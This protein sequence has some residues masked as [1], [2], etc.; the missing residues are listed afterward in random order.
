MFLFEDES[1][2]DQDLL[3]DVLNMFFKNTP[4]SVKPSIEGYRIE[5][6]EYVL[7]C[8][9]GPSCDMS[10]LFHEMGH[11]AEREIPKLLE[12]PWSG[13]GYGQG[14][15]WEFGGRFGFE[16]QTDQSVRREARIWAFQLS[17]QRYFGIQ[18]SPYDTVSA[19]EYLDAFGIYAR[20]EIE[21]IS[22]FS[23]EGKKQ[24][25]QH[26]ANWVEKMSNEEY[27]FERFC[28]DW[29]ERMVALSIRNNRAA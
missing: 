21:G 1:N 3:S 15:Y 7:G 22:P 29:S 6:G 4:V 8:M 17:L 20:K 26:L 9:A 23:E 11:L 28:T 5:N 13:W 16:A 2:L 18:K 14:R 10:N 27:T 24:A 12:R 25:I 19:A